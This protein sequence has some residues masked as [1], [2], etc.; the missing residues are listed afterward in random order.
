M[1]KLP[2]IIIPLSELGKYCKSSKQALEQIQKKYREISNLRED[3]IKHFKKTEEGVAL[4]Q[5]AS[6]GQIVF[7][8]KNDCIRLNYRNDQ[9]VGRTIKFEAPPKKPFVPRL[10]SLDS[11]TANILLSGKL[12]SDEEKR[13]FLKTQFGLD[14]VDSA[15][16]KASPTHSLKEG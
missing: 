11:K 9:Y 2:N 4:K 13:Q 1:E 7:D 16:F 8:E 10:P 5:I 12:L 6:E 15:L 3:V 14:F